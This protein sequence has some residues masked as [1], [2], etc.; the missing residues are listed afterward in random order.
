MSTRKMI[1]SVTVL[2]AL[3]TLAGLF[4]WNDLPNQVASHWGA[5]D[6]VNGTI[7][8]FWGVFLMPIMSSAM[9]LLFLVV[10]S[11]DP[12]KANIAQFRE[13]FN[14]FVVL[15]TGFMMYIYGLT[16]A[17]NLG[18]TGFRMSAVML[19]ALG[20]LFIFAGFLIEK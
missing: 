5:N 12:L 1:V 18:Y 15:I 8:K 2:I 14:A 11:I 17:W 3:S 20:L 9:V 4:H 7:S 6:Q 10:P 19:P 16:L 13:T